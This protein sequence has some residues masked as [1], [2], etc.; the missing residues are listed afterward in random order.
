LILNSGFQANWRIFECL[1]DR[2]TTVIFG[3]FN[4]A[5]VYHGVLASGATCADVTT[6]I[7]ITSRQSLKTKHI[8]SSYPKQSSDPIQFTSALQN[9]PLTRR[10]RWHRTLWSKS[11]YIVD[12]LRPRSMYI[13][14][15]CVEG[16]KEAGVGWLA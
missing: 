12:E 14:V 3:K 1:S 8:A 13:G 11:C 9:I 6:E 2:N 10:S 4:H 16:R 5:S 15:I 7:P